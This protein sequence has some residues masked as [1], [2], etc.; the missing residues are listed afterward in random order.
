[1]ERPHAR[2][3]MASGRT[4]CQSS[5]DSSVAGS[6]PPGLLPMAID[7]IHRALNSHWHDLHITCK[8]RIY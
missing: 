8:N 3:K 5:G 6:I 2:Q 4:I 1:M 7:T